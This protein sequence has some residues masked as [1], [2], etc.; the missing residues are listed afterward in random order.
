MPASGNN[1]FYAGSKLLIRLR[2]GLY[3]K[4]DRRDPIFS[5]DTSTFEPTKKDANV[6]N[7]N[8]IPGTDVFYMDCRV[9]PSYTPQAFKDEVASII[10]GVEK[11]L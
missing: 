9:L 2:E 6:P 11:D 4:F 8:T 5:P 3:A 7:V 1:A 10:K